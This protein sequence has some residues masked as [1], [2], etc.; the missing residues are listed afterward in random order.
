[1]VTHRVDDCTSPR[2]A[3]ARQDTRSRILLADSAGRALSSTSRPNGWRARRRPSSLAVLAFP[4]CS[5]FVYMNQP[6]GWRDFPAHGAIKGSIASARDLPLWPAVVRM[7]RH[8][9]KMVC[10]RSEDCMKR[11]S[12]SCCCSRSARAM[13]YGYSGASR[14]TLK[15]A[16]SHCCLL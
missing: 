12:T 16:A 15:A 9:T 14:P 7:Y 4:H 11:L 8:Y 3:Y 2:G 6:S 10:S 13:C 5:G 1:M